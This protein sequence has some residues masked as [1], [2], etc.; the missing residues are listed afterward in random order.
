MAWHVPL[1]FARTRPRYTSWMSNNPRR[2][3]AFI[4][5]LCAHLTPTELIEAEERFRRYLG[6]VREIAMSQ[7]AAGDV[8]MRDAYL[9]PRFDNREREP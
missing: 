9:P 7:T 4:Q 1:S 2:A 5:K 8:Q 3:I 6:L